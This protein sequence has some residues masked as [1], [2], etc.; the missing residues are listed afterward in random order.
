MEHAI[1][2]RSAKARQSNATADTKDSVQPED[3]SKRKLDSPDEP[4][5]FSN[6]RIKTTS[7]PFAKHSRFWALDGNVILQ[8]G[9]VA[10]KLHRSRLSTQSVWFE[11]LFERRAGREEPLEDD[12]KD[13]EEVVVEDLDGLDSYHLDVVGPMEDFEALLNAMEDAIDFYYNAPPFLTLAAIFRAATTYKFHKF[14]QFARQY[15]L[16]LFSNDVNKLNRAAVPN[17]ALAVHL[18]REW[19]LAGILKR[20]FYELI[21]AQPAGPRNGD[22]DGDDEIPET[23]KHLTTAWLS[24]FPPAVT[25]E[26]CPERKPCAATTRN[27]G[28]TAIVETLDKYQLDPICGLDA[29]IA[30][31]WVSDHGLCKKCTNSRKIFFVRKKLQLWRDM[32]TWLDIVVEEDDEEDN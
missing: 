20:A 19:N 29:L 7:Q 2:T 12:E 30:V 27:G 22:D 6:K 13:I 18:G 31:K 1:V 9:S 32:D 28:W 16:D 5:A 11:K 4:D 21:R 10:F 25:P 14:T 24:V 8:F 23:Q 26:R 17:P 3:S 15:L